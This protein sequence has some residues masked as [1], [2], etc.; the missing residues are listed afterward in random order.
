MEQAIICLASDS[1]RKFRLKLE[2]ETAVFILGLEP[3]RAY[4]VEVDNEEMYEAT[5][6]PGG[7]IE[8]SPPAGEEVGIRVT[9][10]PPAASR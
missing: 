1:N 5:A 9:P 2:Q 10:V 3:R 4:L 8:V 6:D 7:V